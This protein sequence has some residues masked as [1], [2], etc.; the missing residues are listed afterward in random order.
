MK[1]LLS[2]IFFFLICSINLVFS[3]ENS[4]VLLIPYLDSECTQEG[5]V[6]YGYIDSKSPLSPNLVQVFEN[7]NYILDFSE[8]PN[9]KILKMTVL[10][11]SGKPFIS[12]IF[13][14]N[15]CQYSE[16]LKGY[17]LVELNT[18]LPKSSMQFN[19]WSDSGSSG[20]PCGVDNIDSFC[21]VINGTTIDLSYK[22]LKETQEFTCVNDIPYVTTCIDNQN[23]T[24]TTN[25]LVSCFDGQYRA[26]C[27]N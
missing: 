3:Y 17:Y 6:G 14:F 4:T 5:G 22:N 25:Q 7:E 15:S 21:F 8:S 18:D 10:E 1:L 20:E 16:F 23:S 11:S 27:I 19:V 2:I 12:E 26:K 9:G 13:G 24:C